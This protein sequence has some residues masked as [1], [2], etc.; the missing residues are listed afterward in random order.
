MKQLSNIHKAVNIIGGKW[1]IL[2]LSILLHD[3]KRF[4]DFRTEL[5]GIAARQLSKELKELET[6]KLIKRNVYDTIPITIEYE[7]TKQGKTVE[8]IILE[9]ANWG[10]A[11]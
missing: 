1:K 10:S 5:K 6:S 7:L 8:K 9:L 4:K 3:K 2:I 11:K